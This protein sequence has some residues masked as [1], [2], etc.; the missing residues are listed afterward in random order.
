MNPPVPPPVAP[1]PVAEGRSL[2][3]FYGLVLGLNN[4][5]F[6]IR[7]GITGIVGPNGAGKTT[8]FR[9]L[10][11]QI[12]PSSGSIRVFG[13]DPWTNPSVQARLA[14]CPEAETVPAG[15]GSTD[16]LVALGMISGLSAAAAKVRA[17]ECLDRVKLAATHRRKPLTALSKGMRQR[18]KLAQCLLHDPAL[19]ILD[20]PMNGLDPM[21]REDIGN[22]LR[23]LA[24]AGCS[25]LISSHILH[26]LEALCAEFLLLR[27]GRIPR[28]LNESAS[29]DARARWP[30]ATTFRCDD[31][32]RLARFLF[33]RGLLRGCD[34]VPETGLLHVRWRDAAQFYG[35]GHFHELLLASGV[36]L[37]EV[38]A[39]DSRLEK[40]IDTPAGP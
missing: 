20:E 27:W 9:L 21:G 30:E 12:R 24:Q 16:W 36:R 17:G 2:S 33:D 29:A 6:A 23:E 8:L 13:E 32:A 39:T 4:V 3:R 11:G 7:P 1:A 40:A 37:F 28:S 15:L 31:P 14:Y 38:Q 26:D 22:V 34:L 18:A 5:S 25:V 35:G 10:L 19:V